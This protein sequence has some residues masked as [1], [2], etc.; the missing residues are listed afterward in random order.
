MS[1]FR[2]ILP[3]IASLTM[4]FQ[5][6]IDS[7]SEKQNGGKLLLQLH[8]LNGWNICCLPFTQRLLQ[9]TR[10][11]PTVDYTELTKEYSP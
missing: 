10:E 2:F 8:A 5:L 3:V 9:V 11:K 7:N 4:E 1:M 6:N